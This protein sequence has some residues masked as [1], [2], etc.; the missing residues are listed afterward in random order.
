M[1]GNREYKSDVFS[2]LMEDKRNA[3][4]LYNA[5]NGSDYEDPE[6]VELCRLDNGISLTVR[7]DAAFVLDMHLSIYE[8]QST[9]CPNMPLR[10]LIYLSS[11]L[12]RLVRDSNIYGGRLVKIPTPRF[13]V[14]YNGAAE[15]PEQ[16]EMKLSDAFERP[17]QDPELE[18]KC[19]VY[20]INSGKN[21]GL[22]DKC[23][24]LRE[25]MIFVDRVRECH[26]D[27]GYNDLESAIERAIDRCIEDNVLKQFLT[28]RRSE[29]TKMV[30]LDYTFERQI[31]LEREAALAEG[32]ERGKEQWYSQG[33]AQ[34]VS[35]GISQG[36]S[37]SII[38]ILEEKG[39]IPDE[40]EAKVKAENDAEKLNKW[41]KTAAASASIS[42]FREKCSL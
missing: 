19:R 16:Y 11:I 38:S 4:E 37:Q 31:M 2:M 29:V 17:M 8:H 30:Q 40:L 36:I 7:N 41:L 42:E 23:R 21:A 22:M 14:F 18:L 26:S 6:L 33:I 35:K 39:E 3:L 28:T 13:A 25:Y 27:N 10:S 32:I 24:V 12:Q 9:V 15:Q 5:V 1:A 20:N 34:G